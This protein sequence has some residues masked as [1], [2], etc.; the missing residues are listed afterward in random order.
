MN[1]FLSDIHKARF[2]DLCSRDKTHTDDIKTKTLL[3][4]F[5]GTE[6]LYNNVDLLY[7]FGK[8]NIRLEAYDQPFLEGSTR[9]L[10]DLAFHLYG[11]DFVIDLSHFFSNLDFISRRLAIN[12]L[13]HHYEIG[14]YFSL[15]VS[16]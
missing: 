10:I 7:D 15:E 16:A 12:A 11:V 13:Q 3:F 1:L 4:I 9:S 8:H 2:Y 6:C 14:S 5:T